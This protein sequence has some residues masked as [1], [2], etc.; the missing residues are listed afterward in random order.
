LSNGV[1]VVGVTTGAAAHA[2]VFVVVVALVGLR[3]CDGCLT[4]AASAQVA[5]QTS[6][7]PQPVCFLFVVCFRSWFFCYTT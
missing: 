1:V 3:T 6:T 2:Q 4:M 5:Q 7:F